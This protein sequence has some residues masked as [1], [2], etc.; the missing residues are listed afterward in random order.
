MDLPRHLEAAKGLKSQ[1][2]IEP[3]AVTEG[4]SLWPGWPPDPLGGETAQEKTANHLHK[5]NIVSPLPPGEGNGAWLCE[6]KP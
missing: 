2:K 6:A 5:A 3:E 1:K 4:T